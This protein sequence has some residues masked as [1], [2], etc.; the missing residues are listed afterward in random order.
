MCPN[1]MTSWMNANML[2]DNVMYR[3]QAP[4]RREPNLTITRNGNEIL[5]TMESTKGENT[6]K[7]ETPKCWSLP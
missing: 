1:M 6:T 3:H 2:N 4:N 5:T 7:K